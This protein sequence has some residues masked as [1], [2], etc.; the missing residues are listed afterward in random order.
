[1]NYFLTYQTL[2]IQSIW[3]NFYSIYKHIRSVEPASKQLVTELQHNVQEW[4][5]LF[6]SIY[7]SKD[8]TPYMHILLYHVPEVLQR[9]GTIAIFNQQGL[10]KLNDELT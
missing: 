7:Q 5:V 8:V 3:N 9:Y 2:V 10:E 1:M 4:I 6:K